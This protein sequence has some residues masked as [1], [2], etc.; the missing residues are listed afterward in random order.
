MRLRDLLILSL[1]LFL[2]AFAF[3]MLPGGRGYAHF[4]AFGGPFNW[5]ELVLLLL[6][7]VGAAAGRAAKRWP[8]PG[9][10]APALVLLSLSGAWM[11]AGHC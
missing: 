7:A 10:L 1:G 3:L 5:Y 2:L 8:M 4:L 9:G 11:G 6:F